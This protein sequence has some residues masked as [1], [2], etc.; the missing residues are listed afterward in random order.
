[1][2]YQSSAEDKEDTSN[3]DMDLTLALKEAHYCSIF[4]WYRLRWKEFGSRTIAASSNQSK[5]PWLLWS[6]MSWEVT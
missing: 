1:M 4:Y 3:R 6:D 5:R 2:A